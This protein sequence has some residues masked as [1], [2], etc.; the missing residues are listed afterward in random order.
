MP[1]LTRFARNYTAV[2]SGQRARSAAENAQVMRQRKSFQGRDNG[3][4]RVSSSEALTR[5]LAERRRGA[6]AGGLGEEGW[7]ESV[8]VAARKM[9]SRGDTGRE[10]AKRRKGAGKRSWSLCGCCKVLVYVTLRKSTYYTDMYKHVY[11]PPISSSSSSPPPS[12]PF[13]SLFPPPLLD[14]PQSSMALP[15]PP[16]PHLP[17]NL[18]QPFPCLPAP[19]ITAH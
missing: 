9:V 14:C 6:M 19:E 18:L 3:D 16:P 5:E 8:R 10:T 15:P 12:S 7:R 1:L 17:P 4:G 2:T 11:L 13:H